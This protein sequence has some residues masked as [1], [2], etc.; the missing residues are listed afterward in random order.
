[1][2]S[3]DLE[4]AFRA[5]YGLNLPEGEVPWEP[6]GGLG[7]LG[8]ASGRAFDGRPV[9]AGLLTYLLACAQSA[10]SKSDLQQ[11]AIVVLESEAQRERLSALP[12]LPAWTASAP[13]LLVFCADARRAKRIVAAKGRV[14]AGDRLDTLVNAMGDAAIALSVFVVAAE[15]EGLACCPL[16]VVRMLRTSSPDGVCDEVWLGAAA[17]QLS[18]VEPVCFVFN[19]VEIAN[20]PV[21]EQHDFLT[22]LQ[23]VCIAR[24]AVRATSRIRSLRCPRATTRWRPGARRWPGFPIR[25]MRR[26][27]W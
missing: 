16:S 17:F 10:P 5:R 8:R 12:S 3:S 7:L 19:D 21:V 14:Y 22:L 26:C 4:A 27:A 9:P 24:C 23:W 6:R 25:R 18:G 2:T 13:L 15:A 20:Q 1:L 11:Y